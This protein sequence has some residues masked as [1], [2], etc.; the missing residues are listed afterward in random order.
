M[1]YSAR[2][3]VYIPIC[4]RRRDALFGSPTYLSR[5]KSIVGSILSAIEVAT[6]GEYMYTIYINTQ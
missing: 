6:Q 5:C 1:T 4:Q 3:H 2:F